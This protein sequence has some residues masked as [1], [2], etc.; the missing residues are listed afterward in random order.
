MLHLIPDS[1]KDC[2]LENFNWKGF[3][4]LKEAIDEFVQGKLQKGL[5]LIGNPGVGKTHLMIG[6]YKKFREMGKFDGS[7]LIFVPWHELVS[8]VRGL[9]EFRVIPEDGVDKILAEIPIIDDIK[10]T[11]GNVEVAVL[12]RVIEN[13]YDKGKLGMLSTNAEDVEDLMQRWTLPDYWASRL[14]S[15]FD[16]VKVK[17]KDWRL[18]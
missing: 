11:Q 6:V 10:P 7:E 3:D 8:S 16:V 18:K 4:K 17:G 12:R 2:T 5:L 13:I 9:M 1:H 15:R 14:F